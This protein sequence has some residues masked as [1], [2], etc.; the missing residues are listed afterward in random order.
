MVIGYFP[1][2]EPCLAAVLSLGEPL[3]TDL[4]L[5]F[6]AVPLQVEQVQ[7][8]TWIDIG[9]LSVEIGKTL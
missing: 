3:S 4:L 7:L 2:A 6:S 5:P 9:R 8:D 1:A